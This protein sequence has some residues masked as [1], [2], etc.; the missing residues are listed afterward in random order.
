MRSKV[1]L[2]RC[3]NYHTQ[4]VLEAVRNGIDL[5]G[6]IEKFASAGEKILLKPNLL[7][8]E[9]PDKCISPHPEVFRAVA[10]I[11]QDTGAELSYGDS[12]GV[13][14][15]KL[16][17]QRVGYSD[18]AKE[19]SMGLADFSTAIE[20]Q[21]PEGK[22]IK[23]FQIAKG[24]LDCDGIINLPKLKTHGLTRI[25]C[26]VK[27]MFGCIP[28][29]RKSEY[30][31]V[32]QTS[33]LFSKMLV[34]LN[35]VLKPRLNILDGVMAMEGNGPRNG[36]PREMNILLFSED[37]IAMDAAACQLVNLDPGL[38]ETNV[39]GQEFGLG[40]MDNIQ[41]VGAPIEDFIQEDFKVNRSRKKTATD[42][43]FLG[44]S[45]MRRFTAPQPTIRE[46]AC[47]RCGLCVKIC[48]AQPKALSWNG[49]GDNNPP[50]YDYEK[51]IR[52]YCCQEMCPSEAIYIRTPLLGKLIH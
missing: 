31:S 10:R 42:N 47:T 27:N 9:H 5:L 13:G 46:E 25:T 6:G 28:G 50:V 14:S 49:K 7:T 12:P 4:T 19:L 21:F 15:V 11:F 35:R 36:T 17:S 38:V 43:S 24:A 29:I 34:D 44:R 45:Y 33:D 39:Y 51:C 1:A 30:H 37:P 52:C 3:E 48:P 16:A 41:F 32:L 20:V 26:A 40:E 22:M 18:I 23:K 2:V 8:G